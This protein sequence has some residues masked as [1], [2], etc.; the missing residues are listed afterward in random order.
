MDFLEARDPDVPPAGLKRECCL[1]TGGLHHRQGCAAL[2]APEGSI[3]TKCNRRKLWEQ[4]LR[5]ANSPQHQ[6]F[7]SPEQA[8]SGRNDAEERV[9]GH[10]SGVRRGQPPVGQET[11]NSPGKNTY[12]RCLISV[13]PLFL[14]GGTWCV[15]DELDLAPTV[16]IASIS[17]PPRQTVDPN[18]LLLNAVRQAV[19]GPPVS[20]K[21]YQQSVA[22]SQ[23]VILSG[24]Y[25]SAG[26]G[27]GQ[28]R[29]TAR[30]SSG[31][32]TID[33]IQISDGRLMYT[34]IGKQPPQ[35]VNVEKVR[36]TLSPKLHR[37]HELPDVAIHLAIGGHA[38]LLRNLYQRY[39]WYKVVSGK[40]GDTEVW[41]LLGRLRTEPPRIS[42]NARIDAENLT[43]QPEGEGIPT[44]VRLTLGRSAAFPYFPYTV[45]YFRLKKDKD[46]RAIDHVP[47]SKIDYQE[48]TSNVT[49]RESDFLYRPDASADKTVWET[50]LYVPTLP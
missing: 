41:Q 34:Q 46:G 44:G 47:V 10:Q 48:P 26:A 8:P 38:E 45:E 21:V 5:K 4:N 36:E 50:S 12:L 27:T 9:L 20:C 18:D 37:L 15:G 7:D 33:S 42:G 17:N 14:F 13:F 40:S 1:I 6:L 19:L 25:K 16:R 22:Y 32:T 49:L 39:N 29:F 2:R 28:F 35:I 11:F 24:E 23:Q 43:V 30:V 31:E 3:L